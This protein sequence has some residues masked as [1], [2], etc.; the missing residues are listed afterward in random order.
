[1]PVFLEHRVLRFP[2]FHHLIKSWV[3]KNPFLPHLNFL[4]VRPLDCSTDLT[5]IA[6]GAAFI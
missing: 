2:G 3:C 4:R 1:M 5:Q 6:I